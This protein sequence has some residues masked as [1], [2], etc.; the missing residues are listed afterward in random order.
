[1]QVKDISGTV[2]KARDL[3]AD[4]AKMTTRIEAFRDRLPGEEAPLL[5]PTDTTPAGSTGLIPEVPAANLDLSTLRTAILEHG[6]LI[7]RGLFREP[8]LNG[9]IPVIDAVLDACEKNSRGDPPLPGV[10][11]NPTANMT[12]IMPNKAKELGNT[13]NFHRDSGS[14]MCVEAPS[15]AEA[16]LEWYA[17]HGLQQLMTDYLGEPPCL[18]MK[19]WVLRRSRLPVAEAG[20]HQDG[21]FMGTDINSLNMWIPLNECGGTTGSPGMDVVPRRLTRIASADGAQFDW[22]VSTS[23]VSSASGQW[24]SPVFNAGDAFFFDHFCLH[25][26]QYGIDFSQARYAIETWFFGQSRFPK[27]QIPLAW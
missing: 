3:A 21:A 10:Y 9:F 4:R 6:S 22:S 8:A 23:E 2:L 19:K 14:A 20:W 24:Q 25:R 12:G 27:N 16:L 13:R 7:V 5:V 11:F 17:A 26:T 1:M 15:V 18:T